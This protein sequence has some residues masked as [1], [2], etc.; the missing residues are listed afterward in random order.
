[1]ENRITRTYEDKEII[2]YQRCGT[3]RSRGLMKKYFEYDVIKDTST[4]R[5]FVSRSQVVSYLKKL[6]KI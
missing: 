5:E 3:L 2:I 1:M 6:N 4:G